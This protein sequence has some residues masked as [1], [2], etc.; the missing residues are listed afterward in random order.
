MRFETNSVSVSFGSTQALDNVSIALD[1]A[2]IIGL[3]GRNGAG[4]STLINAMT[5]KLHPQ[6]GEIILDGQP[7]WEN[8]HAL[9][10]ICCMSEQN[11]FPISRRIDELFEFSAMFYPGFDMPRAKHLAQVFQLDTR[12]KVSSLSTGYNSIAKNIIAL[13][14]NTP[15]MIMD[16]P[17]LGLDAAHRELFY[18]HLI[19][20]YSENQ[21]MV[22]LST[23]LIEEVSNII[24][25]AVILH[26][27]KLLLHSATADIAQMGYS[28]SGRRDDVV[29]F[30]SQLDLISMDE[31][32]S[33]AT[34]YIKGT[35][36][37]QLPDG[38]EVGKLSLQKVFVELT[39]SNKEVA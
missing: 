27:G 6:G 29:A 38:L 1:G 37:A 33:F 20:D 13:C 4:K 31:I 10:N 11:L 3:L 35:Q 14:C 15:I 30:T 17:V 25:E 8:E 9:S 18:K 22:I 23:H 19:K 12:K 26:D 7:I 2:K 5:N 36:P 32:G 39:G 34:A 16:E 21:R 28:L 24:E